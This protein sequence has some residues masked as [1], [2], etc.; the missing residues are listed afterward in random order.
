MTTF[1]STT[2]IKSLK[3]GYDGIPCIQGSDAS[4]VMVGKSI[5]S[6]GYSPEDV[7]SFIYSTMGLSN[8]L[9]EAEWKKVIDNAIKSNGPVGKN[10]EHYKE[11]L[12]GK[13]SNEEMFKLA[14]SCC[15]KNAEALKCEIC[16]NKIGW[17]KIV[18]AL[19]SKDVAE[20]KAKMSDKTK[21]TATK[22]AKENKPSS[23]RDPRS[24]SVTLINV[25]T[26]EK[27][28]WD[29]FKACE[30]EIGTAHGTV[31]QIVSGDC[32]SSKGW[33]LF[34]EEKREKKAPAVE[35]KIRTKAVIQYAFDKN[36]NRIPLK[37][38][39]SV[40]EASKALRIS[41]SSISKATTGTYDSAGGFGWGPVTKA[42]TAE[43]S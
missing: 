6:T 28:T 15:D 10:L 21:K 18:K 19:I 43:A 26:G 14:A 35:N 16:L 42:L 30:R 9:T 29:S 37:I 22:T 27:K 7:L 23:K 13:L 20:K 39:T 25:N 3:K 40:T 24:K 38:W 4:K 2:F 34:K 12:K 11:V 41:H 31:S 1:N 36:G 33:K 17:D 5:K 8:T 32:K